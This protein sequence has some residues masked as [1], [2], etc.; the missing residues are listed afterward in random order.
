MRR[1]QRVLCA[2]AGLSLM[3]TACGGDDGGGAAAAE[4]ATAEETTAPETTTAGASA[5]G[6]TAA[7]AAAAAAAPDADLP[8][9]ASIM[10]PA[11]P[12]GGWDST[13]RA[14]Q[15]VA[16]PLLDGSIE[17]YNRPGAGG[18]VGL[19]EFVGKAGSGDELMVMGS[20]MVGAIITNDA[21]V[22]LDDVTP[23]A[24]LTTEYLGVA[25]P[26]DSP[27]QTLTELMEAFVADP[28]SVSWGGGSAGGT[29]HQLVALLAD[30][31]GVDPSGINYIAHSGGGELLATLLSGAVS[32]GV[33]GVSELRDQVDGGEL[34]FLAVSSD[35]P[36]DGLDVPTVIES[37]YDVSVSNWRGVVAPPDVSEEDAASLE[38]LVAGV[39]TSAEW[40][41]ELE[42]NGWTDFFQLGDDF[43]AFLDAE[44]ERITT[45]L[46][47]I[48]LT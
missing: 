15:T 25:V 29:D 7:T 38:A 22:S 18:T 14:L 13:A 2:I 34:R 31:A 11:D 12:G 30:A 48:G 8:D 33:S 36:I 43:A 3:A 27:Y 42:R 9:S 10:A 20:V 6:A 41:A 17:V 32:A 47:E 16:D 35:D 40:K 5:S 44:Q 1:T 19:A 26:A 46:S 23:I 45:T 21:P 28:Q 24:S 37:G 4:E 39:A